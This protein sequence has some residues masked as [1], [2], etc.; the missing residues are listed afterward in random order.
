MKPIRNSIKAIIIRD[1]HVL[2]IKNVDREG[3]WYVF[4]GGGQNPGEDMFAALRRECFEETGLLISVGPLRL[5]REYIG[6]NHEFSKSDSDVHQ[7]ELY[8]ECSIM[9]GSEPK[10]GEKK[11]S[12]QVYVEWV[13]LE[14]LDSVRVYPKVFQN[15]L[16]NFQT[17]YLGDVN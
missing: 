9:S 11:D 15:G 8:F 16:H 3:F 7:V 6:K 14:R 10:N 13:S 4:P 12:H 17:I 5:I 1:R 2:L